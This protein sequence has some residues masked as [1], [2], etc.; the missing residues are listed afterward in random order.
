MS[1]MSQKLEPTTVVEESVSPDK[2]I[3]GLLENGPVGIEE[4]A[5]LADVGRSEALSS[6]AKLIATGMVELVVSQ[7]PW[8]VEFTVQLSC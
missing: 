4:V 5:A 3:I 2:R 7:Y 6:V 1:P 8:G